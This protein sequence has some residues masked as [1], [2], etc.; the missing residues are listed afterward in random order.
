MLIFYYL[1]L[2]YYQIIC[3]KAKSRSQ[4]VAFS[5]GFDKWRTSGIR[6]G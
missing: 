4:S 1:Y 3:D 2:N 6:T 5:D